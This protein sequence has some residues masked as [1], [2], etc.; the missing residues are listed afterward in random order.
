MT[1]FAAESGHSKNHDFARA[2]GCQASFR[3]TES[4]G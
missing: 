2:K 3:Y 1:A 4:S